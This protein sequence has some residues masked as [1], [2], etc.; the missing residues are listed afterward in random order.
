MS[1]DDLKER[2]YDVG[3]RA[4][5]TR[6]A[7]ARG[8]ASVGLT[9]EELHAYAEGMLAALETLRG[10]RAATAA[11]KVYDAGR[12]AAC[13]DLFE[14]MDEGAC[15]PQPVRTLP[16]EERVTSVAK[17]EVPLPAPELPPVEGG[18]QTRETARQTRLVEE[19]RRR[20]RK[21]TM[22]IVAG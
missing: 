14:P 11:R 2:L 4:E 8:Q 7:Q 17:E 10:V 9:A 3:L 16:H 22:R 20:H 15:G 6:A 13:E 19:A 21:N 18:I 5:A 12:E 1:L